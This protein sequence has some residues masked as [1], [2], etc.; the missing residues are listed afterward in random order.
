MGAFA[1]L[2]ELSAQT[3]VPRNFTHSRRRRRKIE[4]HPHGLAKL[5]SWLQF[6]QPTK[7]GASQATFPSS[8]AHAAYVNKLEELKLRR[9]TALGREERIARSLAA[10]HRQSTIQLAPIEWRS[11]V[12]NSDIEDEF[13]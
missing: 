4:P 6:L 13:E 2:L 9:F 12:E 8:V 5:G 10:L 7:L 11:V 1:G 3:Q